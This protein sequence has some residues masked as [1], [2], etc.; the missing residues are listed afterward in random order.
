M[1]DTNL[2]Q[3]TDDM[4]PFVFR[5]TDSGEETIDRLTV[6]FCDGDYLALSETGAGFS[7][8]GEA[9]DPAVQEEWVCTEEAKDL[10]LDDLV[11]GLVEH[12]RGR[13]NEAFRHLMEAPDQIIAKDRDSAEPHEGTHKSAGEGLYRKGEEIWIR[14]DGADEDLGPYPDFRHAYLQTLPEAYCLAGPEYH[15]TVMG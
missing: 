3:S 12:I 15:S 9:I 14:R 7:Q 11:P 8:W 1:T 6:T 13:L 10:S 4:K 5:I 2:F